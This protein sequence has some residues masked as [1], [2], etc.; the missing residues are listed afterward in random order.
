M[1]FKEQKIVK[2]S[3]V[4]TYVMA[5]SIKKFGSKILNS[6]LT[7]Y[8]TTI[9]MPKKKN[10]ARNYWADRKYKKSFGQKY[11][12]HKDQTIF[13]LFFSSEAEK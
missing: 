10:N 1:A 4:S 9:S 5:K 2:S 7:S 12:K 3:I 8:C 11:M 13:F 6:D